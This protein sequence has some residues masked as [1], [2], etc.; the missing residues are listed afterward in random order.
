MKLTHKNYYSNKADS[1]FISVSQYKNFYGTLERKGCE[2]QALAIIRGDF[3]K[4]RTPAMLI[5]SYVDAYFEGTLKEFK[6]NTPEIFKKDGTL[7]AEYIKADEMI[8]R[9]EA[10]KRFMQYMS[11]EKQVIM[12]GEI[13]GVKVK[14]KIDSLHPDKIVDLKIRRDFEGVY[15]PDSGKVPWFEAW[16]YDLQGAVYR[17][18]VRQ[19]T[20]KVLPFYLAAATK[21]K[22][23]DLCIVHLSP[24]ML[25]YALDRFKRDIEFFDAVKQGVI[26]PMRCEK[27]DYCKG[28][29]VLTEPTES[30]EFYLDI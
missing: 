3:V 19:N 1:E 30:E 8:K 26:E 27:C 6:E 13:N 25:D 11:G 20:G 23:T 24:Q 17:E 4:E 12:T 14:I 15:V 2:N 21:E 9:C 29:K 18:I 5:G 7:K 28:T 10:D 16:G 22:V